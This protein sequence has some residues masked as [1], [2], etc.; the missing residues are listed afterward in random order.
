[1][2]MLSDWN[3]FICRGLKMYFFF[4]E[5]AT[6]RHIKMN[7]RHLVSKSLQLIL[8]YQTRM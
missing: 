3:S 7:M 8:R 4:F 6:L 1:M 2:D 5:N